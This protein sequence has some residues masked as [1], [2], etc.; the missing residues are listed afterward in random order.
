MHNSLSGS[1]LFVPMWVLGP[2]LQFHFKPE[3]LGRTKS[4]VVRVQDQKGVALL[5][6]KLQKT[7]A[8]G[9]G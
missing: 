2:D 4:A 8:G 3:G 5:S 1:I 6:I 9:Q 7:N